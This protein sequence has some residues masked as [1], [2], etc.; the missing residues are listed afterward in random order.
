MD[1]IQIVPT[2]PPA[3]SGVGD[4][5]TLLARE[6]LARHGVGTRFIVGGDPGWDSPSTVAPFPAVAVASR[7][8]GALR[9][10]LD[11]SGVVLLHYVPY[12]YAHRGCPFWLVDAVERWKRAAG[13]SG[14]LLLCFHEVYAFGPPWGSAFWA[15]PFQR[16]LAARLARAADA[17]RMTTS[18]ASRELRSTLGRQENLPT[19]IVPVFSTL[20]ELADPP[21]SAARERQIVVFGSRPVREEVYTHAAALEAFCARH[22]IRRLVDVGAPISGGVRLGGGV[23]VHETGVLPAADALALFSRSLAGYFSYP[24]PYLGK[25]STFA[26]YCAHRMVPV[27]FAGNVG[28]EDGLRAGEHYLA[29]TGNDASFDAIADAAYAWYRTHRLQAQ[30]EDV[31]RLISAPR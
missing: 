31:F 18:V 8:A 10:L 3:V 25:S 29:G 19:T 17:R 21:P 16:W 11:G 6:L 27:T 28:A 14:R 2:L 26:A 9:R 12:G 22:D 1:L 13:S 15:H 30:A 7:S 4:Y 20:G 5:A 23:E 24:A